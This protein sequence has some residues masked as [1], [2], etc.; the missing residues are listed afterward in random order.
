MIDTLVEYS[1]WIHAA[2][3]FAL[4][5]AAKATALYFVILIIGLLLGR[6][7][8]L[9]RSA[10]WNALL[11]G[12]LVLP[13][14]GAVFPR[15]PMVSFADRT[16]ALSDDEL[17]TTTAANLETRSAPVET[18]AETTQAEGQW[19]PAPVRSDESGRIGLAESAPPSR[20]TATDMTVIAMIV[21]AAVAGF[22]LVRLGFSFGAV[23]AL[24]RSSVAMDEPAWTAALMQWQERLDVRCPLRLARSEKVAVPIVIGWWR[25]T[26]IVPEGLGETPKAVAIDAVLLHELAHVRRGDYAWNLLLR[27]VQII[28]WP[29]PLAWLSGREIAALREQACDEV[30]VF[31]M[32]DAHAYRATLA[33]LAVGLVRRPREAL[34]MAMADGSKLARRLARIGESAGQPHCALS[35]PARSAVVVVVLVVCGL[36]GSLRRGPSVV[37]ASE[38]VADDSAVPV[39]TNSWFDRETGNQYFVALQQ[40]GDEPSLEAG[41]ASPGVQVTVA[42]VE[43][44]DL[45]VAL[46]LMGALIASREVKIHSRVKGFVAECNVEM[47]VRVKKGELLAVIEAPDL[48][49]EMEQSEET[50]DEAAAQREG[51]EARVDAAKAAIES[52]RAKVAEAESAVESAQSSMA[53][54]IKARD[55]VIALFK[56]GAIDQNAL[57]EKEGQVEAAQESLAAAKAKVTTTQAGVIQGA[58]VL[59]EAEAGLRLA[60]SRLKSAER[61][62]ERSRLNGQQRRI[63]APFDGVV[64]EMHA[65]VGDFVRGPVENEPLFVVTTVDRV[66]AVVNVPQQDVALLDRGD[67]ATVRFYGLPGRIMKG[68]VSRT[69]YGLDP[70]TQTMR[71]EI[72]LPNPDGR[73]RAGMF[74][75]V[76]VVL[77][78]HLNTLTVPANVISLTEGKGY[79]YRVVNGRVLKTAV[80]VGKGSGE[81][82]E[83]LE[84]L[85]AGETIVTGLAGGALVDGQ[86]VV[87][88]DRLPGEDD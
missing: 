31:L 26:I 8:V 40:S 54:H 1:S 85:E 74:C 30:C 5:V 38:D 21:Y 41:G 78:T 18:N 3:A 47:G 33:S 84:G 88:L 22:L 50:A 67:S 73:L 43:R 16:S 28:Y 6:R 71:A 35:R 23:L 52:D 60:A 10:L 56:S 65:N 24:R 82:V 19:K 68:E 83:V 14:A 17:S 39:Q 80:K 32:N 76:N 87:I 72:D 79:C 12:L 57:D 70:N 66:V 62:V 45:E 34:G 13:V 37:A 36:L 15:L 20:L 44:T 4:D 7:R 69:A 49:A 81:R 46:H 2:S 48:D 86:E 53:Y 77:E 61:R 75:Q 25:P 29:H 64:S 51:A 11:A 55:R 58:A 63:V 27:L 59:R 9:A 42:K